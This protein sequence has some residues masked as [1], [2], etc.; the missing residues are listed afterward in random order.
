MFSSCQQHTERQRNK[1]SKKLA[2]VVLPIFSEVDRYYAIVYDHKNN[3]Q[4]DAKTNFN[5]LSS[6]IF[7]NKSGIMQLFV[8]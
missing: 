5:F 4:I 3:L 8:F 7:L 6:V 1:S 2:Y